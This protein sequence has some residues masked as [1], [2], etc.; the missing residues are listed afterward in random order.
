MSA[1]GRIEIGPMWDEEFDPLEAMLGQSLFFP[2][3]TMRDWLADVGRQHIRVARRDGRLAAGLAIIPMGQWF[4]GVS[5]PMGGI[6]AVGV[7]PEYRGTGVGGALLRGALEELHAGGV[8]LSALYPA[9]L[10]FYR[11]AGYERAATRTVYEVPAGAI[12]GRDRTLDVVAVEPGDYEALYRVYTQRARESA[13]NLDRPI[14]LWNRFLKPRDRTPYS[15]MVTR[16]SRPEGYI[17]FLQGGRDE[18]LNVRD[19]CA[20]TPEACRRLLAL[21]A[22]HRSM[23]DTIRWSGAPLDPL[24]FLLPEFRYKV[25]WSID[26]M[27][28]IVDVAGALG[29]RGYPPGL[30]AGLHLEVRD[31]LLPWNNRRFVLEL[32][33]GRP[34]VRAGGE[35]RIRVGVRELAALYTGHLTPF[36]LRVVGAIDGPERDLATAGLVFSGPRPW[37]P[38]MF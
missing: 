23:I 15:Y 11:R 13:G 19:I 4:G 14:M 29:A 3:G 17:I 7:A 6:T 22:D 35:G 25:H 38:D 10:T 37:V 27:L 36:E 28:R 5:V 2:P 8:P 18:P 16:D 30:N 31:D 24:L 26:L 20:L 34:H 33:E 32:S 21:L 1:L 9:T 12:G